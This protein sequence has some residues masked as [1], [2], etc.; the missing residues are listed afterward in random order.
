MKP[1]FRERV[2]RRFRGGFRG[3]VLL[4]LSGSTA[5]A[6]IAYLAQPV[7]RRLYTPAEFGLMDV[8][9]SIVG[10]LLPVASLRYEDALMQPDEDAEAARIWQLAVALL[11]ATVLLLC[12]LLPWRDAFA[13]WLNAPELAPWMLLVPPTLLLARLSKLSEVWLTRLRA[14]EPIPRGQV[15]LTS[16][17]VSSRLLGGLPV[18]AA[19]T[20]GLIG[21]YVLGYVVAGVY[22]VR[23]ATRRSGDLL[24]RLPRL[25][26]LRAQ[27]TRYYRFPLYSTP[28]SLLSALGGRLPFFLLLYFFDA[29]TVGQVGLVFLALATPLGLLGNAVSQVFFVH[30]ADALRS[31]TLAEV[32][33]TV[34]RRLVALGLFPTAVLMVAGEDLVGFVFGEA[35]REAGAYALYLGPWLFTMAVASPLTRLFDVLERQRTD[36]TM[37]IVLFGALALAFVAG[38]VSG[39]VETALLYAGVAGAAT[40]LVQLDVLLKLTGLRVGATL[41]PLLRYG[42]L[43]TPLVALVAA[44]VLVDNALVT[45]A[46]ALLAGGGYYL[47]IAWR[48]GLLEARG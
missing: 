6:L 39:R 35:W 16:T 42:L 5:A 48:D 22:L 24:Q 37:G 19:G 2:R 28:A 17:T 25:G 40:R 29:A 23:R 7:L 20:A 47:L 33:A 32:T 3:P 43:A 26:D 12:L 14:F 30:A 27:A 21:G 46:A 8:F 15:L 9:V 1:A 18:V 45:T 34:Y 11:L 13:A 31:R 41:R 10:V 4:L 38:G 44:A 36:L